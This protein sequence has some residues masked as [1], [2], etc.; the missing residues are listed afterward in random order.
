MSTPSVV[1]LI[2]AIRAQLDTVVVPAVDDE[3]ARKTL[4]MVDHLLQTIAVRAEHEIDWMVEH[5]ADVTELAAQYVAA[6]IGGVAVSSALD[7]YRAGSGHGLSASVVTGNY[8]L[9]ATVLSA[10]LEATVTD[11]GVLALA[12][13]ALLRR[14]VARGVE[15]VG[16]FELV[17]P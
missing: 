3:A 14:D 8:A 13:R 4:A 1:A 5:V 11:D 2:S 9:A 16:E 7:A 10:M 15:V 17:P 12:A 6:G